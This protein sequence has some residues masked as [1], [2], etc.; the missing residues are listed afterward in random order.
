MKKK[1]AEILILLSAVAF[2]GW[3]SVGHRIINGNT[4]ASFPQQLDFLRIWNDD[5]I[6]HGSDADYRKS[7]DP[8]EE[9]KHYIDIDNFPEFVSTGQIQQNFDSLAA[10]H[11]YDF[12]MQQGILPWAIIETAHSL[13]A[14]FRNR[15]WDE[16]MLLAADLGHYVGDAHMPLHLSRNYNGQYSGQSGVHSRYES[17][18]IETYQN[19]IRYPAVG[20]EYVADISDFTFKM[21]YHNYTF[22]DSLLSADRAATAFAGNSRDNTYYGQFWQI[23]K[24]FTITLFQSASSKLASL[25]YTCWINA[26][27]PSPTSDLQA[28]CEQMENFTLH[29]NYPNPFNSQTN[30][31]YKIQKEG[32]VSLAVYNLRGQL[33]ETL[34]EG[35]RTPGNYVTKWDAVAVANGPYLIRMEA[36]DFH[37]TRMCVVLK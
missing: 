3:G 30:I 29:Q 19:E 9:N 4:T 35:I 17:K 15:Q 11:N 8:A 18:L 34:Y 24:S 16:A 1:L 21:I 27:S 13:E 7:S 33:I 26:G 31:G 2:I 12:I 22:V 14:A 10:V 37:V 6:S 32:R 28:R 5:L 36:K 20:A 23:S 25:I